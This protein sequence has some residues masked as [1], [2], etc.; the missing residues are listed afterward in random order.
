MHEK[1]CL[2]PT[3][4]CMNC[5]V[6]TP[7]WYPWIFLSPAPLC[8]AWIVL[9]PL[10]CAMHELSCLCPIVLFM[11][12]SVY[13]PICYEWIFLSLPRCVLHEYFCFCSTVL[14]LNSPV[15]R[16]SVQCKNKI[17][18]SYKSKFHFL[19]AKPPCV[20]PPHKGTLSHSM[21]EPCT[22]KIRRLD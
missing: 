11:N 17:N 8:Y 19:P 5:P 2:C 21:T 4:L 22:Y 20:E 7:L 18:I 14:C 13:I 12:S 15:S 10:H 3:V 16:P 6:L 1:S 9:S